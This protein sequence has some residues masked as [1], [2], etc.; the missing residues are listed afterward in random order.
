M[1]ASP[2]RDLLATLPPPSTL[3]ANHLPLFLPS[4]LALSRCCCCSNRAAHRW[5]K[6]MYRM[7]RVSRSISISYPS[8]LTLARERTSSS[9]G[10]CSGGVHLLACTSV[11]AQRGHLRYPALLRCALTSIVSP[12]QPSGHP[13]LQHLYSSLHSRRGRREPA[14]QARTHAVCVHIHFNVNANNDDS[15]TDDGDNTTNTTTTTTTTKTKQQQHLVLVRASSPAAVHVPAAAAWEW[16]KRAP[17]PERAQNRARALKQE[18][19]Y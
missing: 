11:Y 13:Q 9:G 2:C 14:Q 19:A 17:T 10:K 12:H 3:P 15:D 5:H 16:G 7:C 6:L 1:V 8:F 18:H 4:A